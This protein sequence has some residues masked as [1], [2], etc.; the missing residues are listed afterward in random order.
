EKGLAVLIADL[1]SNQ[2]SARENAEK[3]LEKM[4]GVA[5]GALRQALQARPSAEVRRRLEQLID[6]QDREAVSPSP[7]QIRALR[8]IEV[9]ELVG[10]PEAQQLLKSLAK[11]A[12]E[13]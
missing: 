12:P 3:E 6:K 4:G 2:F 11:G 13:A 1:N 9:L 10:T 8:A 5:S 7:D